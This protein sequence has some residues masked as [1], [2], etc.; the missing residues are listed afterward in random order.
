[1]YVQILMY[2]H[3]R[4]A[5]LFLDPCYSTC[6]SFDINVSNAGSCRLAA[7]CSGGPGLHVAADSDWDLLV[8]VLST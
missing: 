2:E 7:G 6:K 5:F 3:E 4:T 1:M 8:P